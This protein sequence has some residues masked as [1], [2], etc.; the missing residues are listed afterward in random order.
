M[1]QSQEGQQCANIAL[2]LGNYNFFFNK[3]P[4]FGKKKQFSEKHF[5][6]VFFSELFEGNEFLELIYLS[7]WDEN[8]THD[9]NWAAFFFLQK[10]QLIEIMNSPIF[11]EFYST[12]SL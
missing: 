6:R 8:G 9:K 2:N 11:R 12:Q 10:K 4:N 3:T 7:Y 1:L 5:N